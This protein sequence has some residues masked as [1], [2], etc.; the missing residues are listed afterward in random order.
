MCRET[1][2]YDHKFIHKATLFWPK[3]ML[4]QSLNQIN[5]YNSLISNHLIYLC[6]YFDINSTILISSSMYA[7][8]KHNFRNNCSFI[9][10]VGSGLAK[11]MKV[12][13]KGGAA[14]DPE[15]GSGQHIN[16]PPSPVILFCWLI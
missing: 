15:S 16:P 3:Q 13:V 9:N 10:I 11:K 6:R 1:Q 12:A 14:V 2:A 8:W 5:Q 4:D 7:G